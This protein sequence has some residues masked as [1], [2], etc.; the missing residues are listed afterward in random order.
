MSGDLEIYALRMPTGDAQIHIRDL[1]AA[2]AVHS[3]HSA[4]ASAAAR[5]GAQV[6]CNRVH[7]CRHCAQRRQRLLQVCFRETPREAVVLHA[8]ACRTRPCCGSLKDSWAS[9]CGQDYTT[10]ELLVPLE[11]RNVRRRRV[12]SLHRLLESSKH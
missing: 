10:T 1:I 8:C 9:I 11:M 12:S 3:Q 7:L 2:D 6:H 4:G 5:Q